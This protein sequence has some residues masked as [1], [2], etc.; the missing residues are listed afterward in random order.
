MV[1]IILFPVSLACLHTHTEMSAGGVHT[2]YSTVF[3]ALCL[4]TG[5][6]LPLPLPPCVGV[7]YISI[8]CPAP[9]Q[10]TCYDWD[11]DGSHDLIGHFELTMADLETAVST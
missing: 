1:T 11:S 9:S 2:H 8:L 4:S 10:V 6:F 5:L 7:L 3:Y